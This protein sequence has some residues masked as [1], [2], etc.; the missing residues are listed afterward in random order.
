MMTTAPSFAIVGGGIIGFTVAR[1]VCRAFPDSTVTLIDRDVPGSGASARSAGLHFP[2]GRYPRVREMSRYSEEFYQ[3]LR[4]EFPGAPIHPLGLR[5]HSA[6]LDHAGLSSMFTSA[7]TPLAAD[8]QPSP[9][10]SADADYRV[11]TV[12]DAQYADVPALIAFYREALGD[13]LRTLFGLKIARIEETPENVTLSTHD[14]LRIDADHLILCPGPWAL[15]DVFRPYT[16][17]LDIRIKRVVAFHIDAADLHEPASVPTVDLFFD[18][19]AFFMPWG[20]GDKRLFSFTRKK[21]D[22]TPEDSYGAI[23]AEDRAE[24]LAVL[25][26][27]APQLCDA[28]GGGQV[29]CDAYS[30][31]GAPVVA[32]VTS[33]GRIVFAGAA[34]G[35]GY[36]L[37]PAIARKTLK[38]IAKVPA[39]EMVS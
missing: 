32:S 5:V 15:S 31:T 26:R 34:N 9:L 4:A 36:R 3:D 21:W 1:E 39:R 8:E 25:A 37:A 29:F 6:K 27:I 33:S 38:A 16:R 35:S 18:E 30:A 12:D 11:W 2:L 24:A 17:N 19:D 20:K 14:G 7:V 28:V 22:V 23:T 10:A 13:R